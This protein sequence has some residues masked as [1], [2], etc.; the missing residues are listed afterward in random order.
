MLN[1]VWEDIKHYF[2]FSL[3]HR[4]YDILF[5]VTKEEKTTTLASTCSSTEGLFAI[6]F[7]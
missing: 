5:V 7:G 3:A 1:I 4:F 2:N 6:K